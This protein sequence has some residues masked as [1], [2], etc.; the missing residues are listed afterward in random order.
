MA[1]LPEL[2]ATDAPPPD[3]PFVLFT[4]GEG[5]R[6]LF[7]RPDPPTGAGP[8]ADWL[9]DLVSTWGEMDCERVVR[10]R[11]RHRIRRRV[12]VGTA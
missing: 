10:P 9:S 3:E 8:A 1:R 6:H 7:R 5:R 11:R 12:R 2:F 4:T